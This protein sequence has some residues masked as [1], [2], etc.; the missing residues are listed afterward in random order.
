M[1]C[2]KHP[3][4]A[5]DGVCAY[6]GKPYCAAEL[7]DVDGRFYAKDNVGKVLAEA[8]RSAPSP[9]VFMNAGGASSAVSSNGKKPINH[10]LHAVL[11]LLTCGLWLPVWLI[12]AC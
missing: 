7:V 11:T 6:S 12:R 5:A 4:H 2:V 10:V 3:E 8:K 1:Q 9:N